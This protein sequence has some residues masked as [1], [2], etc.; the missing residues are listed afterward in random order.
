MHQMKLANA[1][2]DETLC[3]DYYTLPDYYLRQ[4]GQE[5]LSSFLSAGYVKKFIN[6]FLDS[7]TGFPMAT[8]VALLV[9]VLLLVVTRFS[10]H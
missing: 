1:C 3:P 7:E 4:A 8:N 10:I 6:G 2:N 5:M 9:L